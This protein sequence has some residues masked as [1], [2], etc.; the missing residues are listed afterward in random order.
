MVDPSSMGTTYAGQ[1]RFFILLGPA[2]C[3]VRGPLFPAM[4]DHISD[5]DLEL[6]ST[7][8]LAARNSAPPEEHLL[9][10][11]RCRERLARVDEYVE[12]MREATKEAQES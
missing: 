7:G 9:I 5:D 12:V 11:V 1:C 10:C 8:R 6:Y 4:A 3:E 2:Y